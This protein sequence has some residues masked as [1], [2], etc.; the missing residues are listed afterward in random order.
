MPRDLRMKSDISIKKQLTG[1]DVPNH[2]ITYSP[3][4]SSTKWANIIH[5]V[6]DFAMSQKHDS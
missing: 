5:G 4:M 3:I 2:P 6:T 1:Q